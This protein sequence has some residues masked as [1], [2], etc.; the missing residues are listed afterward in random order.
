MNK[1]QYNR[2]ID[3]ALRHDKS[4]K[5]GDSIAVART[6]FNYLGTPF[7][8]GTAQETFVA[9]KYNLCNGW[10]ACTLKEVQQAADRGDAAIGINANRMVVFAA[11]NTEPIIPTSSV[12]C[13]SDNLLAIDIADLEFYIYHQDSVQ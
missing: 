13:L 2:A 6:I 1:E 11:M 5:M 8:R 4:R 9:I 7:P 12:I 3:Y 10:K